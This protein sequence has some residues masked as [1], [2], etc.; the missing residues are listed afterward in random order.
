MC[1]RACVCSR[2][3]PWWA[4]L[5]PVMLEECDGRAC[6]KEVRLILHAE[7]LKVIKNTEEECE[8]WAREVRIDQNGGI[9]SC[10]LRCVGRGC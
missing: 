6:H 1:V 7:I 10:D 9:D 5:I 2:T 3:V 4:S 8:R